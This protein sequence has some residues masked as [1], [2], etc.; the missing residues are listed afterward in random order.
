MLVSKYDNVSKLNSG[1]IQRCSDFCAQFKDAGTCNAQRNI[2]CITDVKR[3][4]A[5]MMNCKF[6]RNR[7]YNTLL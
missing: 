2:N 3:S 5:Y 4:K 7:C 1:Q 6:Y